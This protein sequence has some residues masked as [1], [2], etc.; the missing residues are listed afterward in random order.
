MDVRFSARIRQWWSARGGQPSPR[1]IG[2]VWTP[3][4]RQHQLRSLESLCE[5]L[6]DLFRANG[7]WDAAGLFRARAAMATRL[8]TRGYTQVELNAFGEKFPYGAD[9]LRPGHRAFNAPRAPWQ[10]QAADLHD[11]AMAVAL[12]LGSIATL[13]D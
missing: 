3:E 1:T 5:Q 11:Q 12:D 10:N 9:W 4:D 7:D 13:A 2:H 6:A 8:L